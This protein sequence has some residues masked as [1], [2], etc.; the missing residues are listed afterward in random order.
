MPFLPPD[1]P[2]ARHTP[3]PLGERQGNVQS[4][5]SSPATGRGKDT[6]RIGTQITTKTADGSSSP[7]KSKS[8]ANLSAMFAKM[9]RSSKYLSQEAPK[10]KENTAPPAAANGPVETPI[11]AQFARP[12]EDKPHS[13]P[14]TR[15]SKSSGNLANEIARYT[16]KDYSP[17][18]QRNFNG[19]LDQPSL[20]P[21]LNSRPHSTH[22]LGTESLAAAIGRRVTG[23]RASMEGRRSNDAV[24]RASRGSSQFG[25]ERPKS[26]ARESTDRKVSDS[27]TEQAPTQEK[28]NVAKRGGKVM[29]AVA[30][31][32]G[33]GRSEVPVKKEAQ[34]DP[35]AVD[36]AFESVLEQRQIPEPMRQKMRSLTLRV[37]AD[38]V[39]QHEGSGNSPPGSLTA[40]SNNAQSVAVKKDPVTQ[41]DK[42]ETKRSRSRPRSRTFTFSKGDKRGDSPTKKERAQS[43]SRPTSVYIPEDNDAKPQSTTGPK[44]PFASLGRKAAPPTVPT[45]Y[46]KYLNSNA[47]PAKVEVGRLHKLRILLRN[48][49]VAW[50]DSFLS[51]GGMTEIVGLLH[52]IMALEWREEHEDQLLHETL[53]C[54]KGLCTTERAMQELA[55]VADKLFPALLAM[56]FDEEKKGPAEYSTRTVIINVLCEFLLV[57]N[58]GGIL[59]D[60]RVQSISSRQLPPPPL[61]PSNPTPARFSHTSPNPPKTPPKSPWTSSLTCVHLAL[62]E[63]GPAKS[64]RSPKKYSGSSCTR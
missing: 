35:K 42:K 15:D 37:K 7:K 58:D 59:A 9:R 11:W 44:S 1:H 33:R 6:D 16:P 2:H 43:K 45:D 26:W 61:Q 55:K 17:S 10:D 8:S 51:L 56:L 47:D 63:T 24:R 53:L 62:T 49:T 29:A 34:L 19:G 46:I 23:S 57:T 48:E 32:Q 40:A 4:P 52:R 50:V 54:L 22:I 25:T 14:G 20:R 64:P 38:F 5:P 13:R 30:A 18:R 28:L 36:M 21:A 31:F 41:E 39:K 12:A 60:S 3:Q 27:S